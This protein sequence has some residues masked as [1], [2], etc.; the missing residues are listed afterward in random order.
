MDITTGLILTLSGVT[1]SLICF[2]LLICSGK[3]FRCQRKTLLHEVE[4]E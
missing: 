3:L 2:V 1:G 4:E